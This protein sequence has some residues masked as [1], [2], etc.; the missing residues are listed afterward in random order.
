MSSLLKIIQKRQR[1]I[2]LFS[3]ATWEYGLYVDTIF[4]SIKK[5]TKNTA[6][7]WIQHY[8]MLGILVILKNLLDFFQSFVSLVLKFNQLDT[9]FVF[10]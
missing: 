9:M 1:L 8:L 6:I 2:I 10:G 3:T 4:C 7:A 5:V